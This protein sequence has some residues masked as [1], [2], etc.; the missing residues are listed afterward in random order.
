MVGDTTGNF[1]GNEFTATDRWSL[2]DGGKTMTVKR[3]IA[4]G[5]DEFDMKL[6]FVKQ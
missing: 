3:H 4:V 6:V 1:D 2:S 5:G